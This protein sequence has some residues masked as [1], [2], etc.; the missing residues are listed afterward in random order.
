MRVRQAALV[1]AA[2]SLAAVA[3]LAGARAASGPAQAGPAITGLTVGLPYDGPATTHGRQSGGDTWYNTWAASGSIYATSDDSHGYHGQCVHA[4]NLAVNELTGSDPSELGNPYT[5][6]MTSYGRIGSEGDYH[7]G[8]TWKSE[9][10]IAVGGTLYLAVARQG[11]G[12][13]SYPGGY[14]GSY[15]A[16]LVKSGNGGRTW[17]NGFGTRDSAGGAAPPPARRGGGARSMFPTG[18]T[19]PQFIQYGQ[20]SRVLAD[21]SGQYVYAMSNDGYAYDGSYEIL[22][23]VLRSQIG[24]LSAASWQFYTGPAGGNGGDPAD[25]TSYAHIAQATRLISAPHQL[26][27]ASVV[28]DP[29]L[30]QYVLA[31]FYYPF[32]AEWPSQDQNLRTTWSFYTAPHPWGPW[33]QFFSA[34]T[35]LCYVACSDAGTNALGLYDPALVPKFSNEDGLG[36]VA[37]ASGDWSAQIR[38]GDELYRLHA[39]PLTLST[40]YRQ[41]VDDSVAG[42]Y[43]GDWVADF[44]APGFTDGTD[45]YTASCSASVSYTFTGTSIAWV[46]SENYNHGTAAVT[47]DGGARTTVRTYARTWHKEVVLFSRS[48]LSDGSHT[49]R[50]GPDCTRA[51]RDT[52][53]DVD[54]FIVGS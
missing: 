6:C 30:R 44:D 1:T 46:G 28:F 13:S 8:G 27:Q 14:Q 39:F 37:F 38:P 22:G 40:P 21:G 17:S 10:I 18:F 26:S 32:T 20:A 47:I 52:Y 2:V 41:V 23:R 12:K 4:A 42:Y 16:S 25:W 43:R 36:A 15:D 54:A 3:S 34:P 48:G 7:D 50:I 19:T 45:H 51:T 49:I 5:N 9:G 31:S 11:D 33:Q 24:R 35:D 53:Q 29:A